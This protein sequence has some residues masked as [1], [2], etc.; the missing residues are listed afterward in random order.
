MGF[1]ASASHRSEKGGLRHDIRGTSSAS[2]HARLP[3]R[4]LKFVGVMRN[5]AFEQ[6]SS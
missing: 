3:P 4:I 2:G 6:C 5:S 1:S